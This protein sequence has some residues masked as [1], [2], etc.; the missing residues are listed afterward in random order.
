MAI[1]GLKEKDFTAYDGTR[2]RYQD[3]GEGPVIVLANGLG[4][5]FVVWEYLVRHLM[6]THRVL[7]WDYRG[8]FKSGRP[9]LSRCTIP[10]HADDLARLMDIESVDEATLVGWSMGSQVVLEHALRR[11]ERTTAIVLLCGAAGRPFD[12]ALHTHY[13]GYVL[14]PLFH[15]MK[16]AHRPYELIVRQLAHFPQAVDIIGATGLFWQGGGELIREML[17]EYVNMEMDTY[18]QIMIE[19]GRHD[20]RPFLREITMPACVIAATRDFFTPV[21][22]AEDASK[23]LPDCRLHVLEGGTHYAP[24]EMPG[25]INRYIEAFIQEMVVPRRR[26]TMRVVSGDADNAPAPKPK[27]PRKPRKPR[28]SANA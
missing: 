22:V 11:P 1:E 28:G 18:A 2:I 12:T 20:A 6:K 7:C 3:V 15:L 27:A 10:D 14:P 9:D 5:S 25:E 8:L 19:L 24:L 13:A 23:M 26:G 4:G 17:V 21:A 16:A